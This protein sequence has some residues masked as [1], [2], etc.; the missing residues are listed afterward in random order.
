MHSFVCLLSGRTSIKITQVAQVPLISSVETAVSQRYI[1]LN[2]MH[3]MFLVD[4]Y[5]SLTTV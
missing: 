2:T 5:N 1:V 3:F 4:I